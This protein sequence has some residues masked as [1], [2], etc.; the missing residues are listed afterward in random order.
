ME[1]N[2][3]MEKRRGGRGEILPVV[4]KSVI[5]AFLTAVFGVLI[6]SFCI[7]RGILSEKG[8]DGGVVFASVLGTALGGGYGVCK[9]GK[10]TLVVGAGI[11]VLSFVLFGV[12]GT[13]VSGGEAEWG[14]GA[15]VVAAACLCGGA[16]SGVLGGV[17][18]KKKR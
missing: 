6:A 2:T 11:G 9:V 1:K 18:P 16:A 5:L 7:S 13:L 15:A 3:R 10:G 14:V 8:I 12:I 4:A 17:L